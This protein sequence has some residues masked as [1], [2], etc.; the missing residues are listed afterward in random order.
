MTP[1]NGSLC[2]LPRAHPSQTGP[3]PQPGR[4]TSHDLE[5]GKPEHA[6]IRS[7]PQGHLLKP[8]AALLAGV[9]L[10]AH[11]EPQGQHRKGHALRWAT[12]S[13]NA[14][15]ESLAPLLVPEDAA[16]AEAAAGAG[17]QGWA[18]EQ[19]QQG[20]GHKAGFE[21]WLGAWN[22]SSACSAA[23]SRKPHSSSQKRGIKAQITK[24]VATEEAS[25]MWPSKL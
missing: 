8:V 17:C 16:P 7:L 15:P 3:V 12:P 5:K 18:P 25:S 21:Q 10:P 9:E 6:V 2:S 13:N 19:C 20:W 14:W 4:I 22:T 23:P 11:A 1:H 24:P